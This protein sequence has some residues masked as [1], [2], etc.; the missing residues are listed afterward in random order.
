MPNK[1]FITGRLLNWSLSD[2]VTR[3]I[4][5]VGVAY[6]SDVDKA[7]ALMCEAA[8]ENEQVLNDPQPLVSF[9]GFGDN[10]LTLL[11]RAYIDDLERRVQ[12]TTA[13]HKA[14]NQKLQAAGISIAFPQRDLHLDTNGPLR[15]SIENSR[16]QETDNGSGSA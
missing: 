2:Q 3:L 12:T 15:V 14:I 8:E 11:L 9:E 16:K 4:V 10:S 13:L 7:L 5:G 1:E 6:G